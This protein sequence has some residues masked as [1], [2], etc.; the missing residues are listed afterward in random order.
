MSRLPK[1]TGNARLTGPLSRL[2]GREP[3][4]LAFPVTAFS[5]KISMIKIEKVTTRAAFARLESEW[6]ALLRNSESDTITLTHAW[7]WTWW[8]VF[9]GGRQLCLLL[10]REDGELVGIAPLLKRRVRRYGVSLRR[11]EF[12]ASGEAEADEICSD[13]LDFIVQ[14][15]R[16]REVLDAFLGYLERDS[17]W[18][19]LILTD[20]AGE[21]PNL[22][23]LRELGA[24]RGLSFA[25]TREQTCIFV[26]LPAT[27]DELLSSISSQKRKRLRKDRRTANEQGIRVESV[28]SAVGFEAAF[29][30]MIALHQE[31]WTTRGYPGSFSSAKFL[32]F[33]RA[34]AA[35]IVGRG[36]LKI[37]LLWQDDAPLCAV[38]D[39]VYGGKIFHYQS[40]L[41]TRE[42]PLISPGLL[43]WDYALEAGVAEGLHEC[44]F[45]K[46]EVG[47]YKTSWGGQTRPIVQV[48][49]ARGGAR[50]MLFQSA[51]RAVEVLR[52][53]RRRVVAALKK[54]G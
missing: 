24:A 29:E 1:L 10:A 4:S 39:F 20:I 21:S 27:R 14:N 6:D 32:R 3:V 22:A 34:L 28:Q 35:R 15:G 51:N 30:N 52:P 12:L 26:P 50:E 16:E 5:A 43:I 40:G 46:G 44:D 45:L 25:V 42:T 36:W 54:R 48:R 7:L 17:S 13:Y 23:P 37:M 31:R 33:H 18:D 2:R 49:L 47:G 11:V 41:S 53:L 8:E 19:E 38:Y 9:R